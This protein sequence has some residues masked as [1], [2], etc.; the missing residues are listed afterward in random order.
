M[1]ALT[2]FHC[3]RHNDVNESEC[4]MHKLT[5]YSAPELE[6]DDYEQAHNTDMW[7][8]GVIMLELAVGQKLP[9][10]K[11]ERYTSDNWREVLFN[12]YADRKVRLETWPELELSVYFIDILDKLIVKN[13]NDRISADEFIKHPFIISHDKE[14]LKLRGDIKNQVSKEEL[15][16]MKEKTK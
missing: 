4:Q 3:A 15:D 16:A 11:S 9:K 13:P 8:I 1:A 7:S 10:T 5:I 12:D 6:D 14:Y 2:G